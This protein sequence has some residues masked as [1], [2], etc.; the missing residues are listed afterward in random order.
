MKGQRP[1]RRA[2]FAAKTG[3]QAARSDK[4]HCKGW[5]S[6]CNDGSEAC[7]KSSI[8]FKNSDLPIF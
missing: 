1:A 6:A 4:F 8:H 2:I 3:Q 7:K 5:S